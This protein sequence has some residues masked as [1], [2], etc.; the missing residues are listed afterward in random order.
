[1]NKYKVLKQFALNSEVYNVGELVEIS[2]VDAK[3]LVDAGKL[4]SHVEEKSFKVEVD[5]KG[6]SDAVV[7][8]LGQIASKKEVVEK[9][10]SQGDILTKLAN[11]EKIDK[12]TINVTTTTQGNFAVQTVVD[13]NVSSDLLVSSGVASRVTVITMSGE[14]DIWKKVVVNAMG[15]APAVFAESATITASQPTITS[16]T[17]T[18]EKVCYRFDVTQEALDDINTVVQEINRDVPDQYSSFIEGGVING[19]GTCLT[20]IVGHAQTVVAPYVSL[21]PAGS[22]IFENI[23]TMLSSCKRPER[24][25]WVLSRSAWLQVLQLEDS[26]GN[27]VWTGGIA[28]APAGNLFGIPIVLSD[29][30]QAAGTVGDIILGDFSDYYIAAKGGLTARVSDQVKF[31]TNESVFLFTYRFDGQPIGLKLTAT[32]NTSIGSFVVLDDRLG[33]T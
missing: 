33:S 20:G 32:D 19:S 13:P 21:Q 17:F 18:P 24:S 8:A 23:V 1:M 27:R 26:N 29:K 12:K 30:C 15:T 9:R 5:S 25:V 16:F 6:I 2:D 11:G 3:G 28:D 31:L 4:V 22:I 10:L 14:R 7:S